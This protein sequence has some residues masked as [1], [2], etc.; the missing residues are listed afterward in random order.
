MLGVRQPRCGCSVP[1]VGFMLPFPRVDANGSIGRALINV[2]SQIDLQGIHG[3]CLSFAL[4]FF[5]RMSKRGSCCSGGE[6]ES[7]ERK[8]IHHLGELFERMAVTA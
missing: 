8:K 6:Q 2:V 1:A 4:R 7:N 5:E 3:L